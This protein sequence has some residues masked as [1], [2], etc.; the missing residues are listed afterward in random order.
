MSNPRVTI[1]KRRRGVHKSP[2]GILPSIPPP[3]D[4]VDDAPP[5]LTSST[6]ALPACGWR[7]CRSRRRGQRCRNKPT[8][9][10]VSSGPEAL[11][12]TSNG[13]DSNARSAETN[14]LLDIAGQCAEARQTS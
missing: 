6:V 9:S 3:V 8:A 1:D 12:R 5:P 4:P 14:P 11:R 7:L 13:M 2:G 10:I